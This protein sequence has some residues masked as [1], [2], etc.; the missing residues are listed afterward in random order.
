[1]QFFTA[2]L[3][4]ISLGLQCNPIFGQQKKVR[5]ILGKKEKK[6]ADFVLLSRKTFCE[7]FIVEIVDAVD[8]DLCRRTVGL[9]IRNFSVQLF[10]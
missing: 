9:S 8:D 10:S 5:R 4:V 6:K 1:M 7:V 2:L 3:L